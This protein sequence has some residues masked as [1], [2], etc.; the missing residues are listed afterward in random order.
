MSGP[1]TRNCDAWILVRRR[2]INLGARHKVR[3][4]QGLGRWRVIRLDFPKW[5][6]ATY[7][8]FLLISCEWMPV[9][10]SQSRRFFPRPLSPPDSFHWSRSSCFCS[11]NTIATG[12]TISD[13]GHCSERIQVNGAKATH[14]NW[15]GRHD[16]ATC[17]SSFEGWVVETSFSVHFVWEEFAV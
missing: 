6:S 9:I 10:C 2:L 1:A 8:S 17:T 13:F 15:I 4:A 5:R 3:D 7:G 12:E 16:S 14:G 11:T